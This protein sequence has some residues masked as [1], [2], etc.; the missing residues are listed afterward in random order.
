[1]TAETIID[2]A[3]SLENRVAAKGFLILS[4][5]LNPKAKQVI[6]QFAADFKVMRRKREKEWV[7]LLLRRR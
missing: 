5:V 4:G 3:G 6:N 1:L 7:T 2:L